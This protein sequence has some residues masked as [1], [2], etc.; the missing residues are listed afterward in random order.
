[1][2]DLGG[3]RRDVREIGFENVDLIRLGQGRDRW[4]ALVKT[5]MNLQIP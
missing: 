2:E 1:L 4:L 3:D 5:V